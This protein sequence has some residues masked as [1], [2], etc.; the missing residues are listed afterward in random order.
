MH[1]AGIL[2]NFACFLFISF[3]IFLLY[4]L[5]ELNES[6][7]IDMRDVSLLFVNS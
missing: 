1:K 7:F 6:T 5:N 3:Y 4:K 2:H